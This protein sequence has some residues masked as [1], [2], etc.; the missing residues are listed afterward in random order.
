M[1]LSELTSCFLDFLVPMFFSHLHLASTE[2]HLA[3]SLYGQD[4]LHN[5]ASSHWSG[6]SH[7]PI[8]LSKHTLPY[9]YGCGSGGWKSTPDV[10]E[11]LPMVMLGLLLQLPSQ[12]VYPSNQL[13]S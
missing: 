13:I 11:I 2:F 8:N 12:P 1:R 6:S 7:S 3:G 10:Y 5:S 4:H 9:V